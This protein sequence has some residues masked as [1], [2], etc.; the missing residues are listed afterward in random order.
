MLYLYSDIFSFV[1]LEFEIFR[2]FVWAVAFH[3]YLFTFVLDGV[4]DEPFINKIDHA[5]CDFVFIKIIYLSFSISAKATFLSLNNNHVLPF[6]VVAKV[7]LTLVNSVVI[8]CF[9]DI[10]DSNKVFLPILLSPNY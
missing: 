3:L 2:A 8:N 4:N 9:L 10:N 6:S 1:L 5:K 7:R